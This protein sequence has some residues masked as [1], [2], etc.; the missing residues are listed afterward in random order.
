MLY[1]TSLYFNVDVNPD[2]KAILEMFFKD[3][4]D[5]ICNN[6]VRYSVVSTLVSFDMVL[7]KNTHTIQV[8]FTNEE[9][10]LA[11][12]LKGVPDE[13]KDYITLV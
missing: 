4:V 5:R 9:D 6:E 7:G 11:M 3:W 1:K 10:A 2:K 8:D 13:F 12:K